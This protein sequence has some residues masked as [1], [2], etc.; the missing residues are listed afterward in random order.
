M[1]KLSNHDKAHHK[2]KR[3]LRHRVTGE[4]FKNDGWTSNLG[5]ATSF[6]TVVEVA[7]VCAKRGLMDVELML[8]ADGSGAELFCTT[9]R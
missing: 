6:T 9:I 7:E 8:C 3:L 1:A 4:Y 5:E 2:I